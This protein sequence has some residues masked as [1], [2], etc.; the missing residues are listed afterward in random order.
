[1]QALVLAGADR[2]ALAQ[3]LA[4]DYMPVNLDQAGLHMLHADPPIF[5]ADNFLEAELCNAFIDTANASGRHAVHL[6]CALKLDH[7]HRRRSCCWC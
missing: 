7:C 5:A 2:S 1:M 3:R 6:F 4:A